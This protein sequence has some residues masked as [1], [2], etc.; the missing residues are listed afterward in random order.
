M[1]PLVLCH[2]A[3]AI[4]FL[5]EPGI[6]AERQVAFAAPILSELLVTL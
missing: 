3:M 2:G 6:G 4:D 1:L 5:G